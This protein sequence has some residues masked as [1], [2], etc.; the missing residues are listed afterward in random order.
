MQSG[1]LVRLDHAATQSGKAQRVDSLLPA[2]DVPTGRSGVQPV[3]T[4]F[5][6]KAP[7]TNKPKPSPSLP[8]VQDIML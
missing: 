2:E 1:P 6:P 3:D 5:N 4:M 7:H 8:T